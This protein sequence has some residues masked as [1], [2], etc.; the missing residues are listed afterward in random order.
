MH[1]HRR[2]NIFYLL[3]SSEIIS[4]FIFFSFEIFGGFIFF[5]NKN[6]LSYSYKLLTYFKI[7]FSIL[8]MFAL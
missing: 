2:M 1:M 7:I 6:I 4:G 3:H 8:K 5:C